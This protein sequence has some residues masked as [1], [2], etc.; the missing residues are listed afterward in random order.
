[1]AS[2][3]FKKAVVLSVSILFLLMLTTR[4]EAGCGRKKTRVHGYKSAVSDLLSEVVGSVPNKASLSV[5]RKVRPVR[6]DASCY[7]PSSDPNDCGA[8]LGGVVT[9]L[10]QYCL[11]SGD[12]RESGSFSGNGCRVQYKRLN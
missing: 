6:V 5:T 1:M 2:F 7:D 8:C 3:S 11:A 4:V 12:V 9:S 10:A